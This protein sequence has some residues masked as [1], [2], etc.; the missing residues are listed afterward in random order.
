MGTQNPS[1]YATN[2]KIRLGGARRDRTADLNTASVALSQLSYGPKK[3]AAKSKDWHRGCQLKR[4]KFLLIS[5][6][7][8]SGRQSLIREPVK[9]T[10]NPGQYA[11]PAEQFHGDIESGCRRATGERNPQRLANLAKPDLKIVDK[12]LKQVM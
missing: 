7:T 12:L 1:K 10:V 8:V 6:L 9:R 11:F 3:R 2:R 4:P 5:S